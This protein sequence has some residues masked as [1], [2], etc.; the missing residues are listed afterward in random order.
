MAAKIITYKA[1]NQALGTSYTPNSYCASKKKAIDGGGDD[2]YGSGFANNR[3]ITKVQK[4]TVYWT[5]TFNKQVD[6]VVSLIETRQVEDGQPISNPPVPTVPGYSP[7]GW[8]PAIPNVASQ[9]ATYTLIYEEDTPATRYTIEFRVP[10]DPKYGSYANQLIGNTQSLVEGEAI[11][12]PRSSAPVITYNNITYH[13]VDWKERVPKYATSSATYHAVYSEDEI[14]GS[15]LR[16]FTTVAKGNGS[17]TFHVSDGVDP[18]PNHSTWGVVNEVSYRVWDGSETP[19]GQKIYSNW[20]TVSNPKGQDI[21]VP[22]LQNGYEVEWRGNSSGYGIGYYDGTE[23]HAL[24][25]QYSY[26]SSTCN[27]SI[28]NNL[29][30]L[31]YNAD[32]DTISD[33][34]DLWH[35]DSNSSYCFC[36]LFAGCTT[37]T[38]AE[39]LYFPTYLD[40]GEHHF[41]DFF[42]DCT[43]LTTASFK[44]AKQDGTMLDSCYERMF[45]GCSSLTTPPELPAMNL[46]AHC[47]QAMFSG[48]TSL[49]NAPVL[50]ATTLATGCYDRMFGSYEYYTGNY[51][52]CTS[53]ARIQMAAPYTHDWDGVTQHPLRNWAAGIT[54][55][56]TFVGDNDWIDD[57]SI[58]GNLPASWKQ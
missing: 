45:L 55:T 16:Y 42:R 28:K 8:S 9:D 7:T 25:C 40:S 43:N 21:T 31:L 27:M 46:G 2:V 34:D 15:A 48:C 4:S 54:Q 47:Y 41:C 49:V 53:L 18:D 51:P 38:S 58:P 29:L 20:T 52:A 11:V 23:E 56:G 5:I 33:I 17:I 36:G 10:N 22:N 50:P 14:P 30:T 57:S 44:C 3:L 37:L 35:L 6:G 39:D 13:F 19:G 1:V 24:S 12:D 26:F 32:A